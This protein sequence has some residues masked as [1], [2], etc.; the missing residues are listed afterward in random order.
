MGIFVVIAFLALSS[1]S[2]AALFWRLRQQ[3]VSIR[4]WALF[5]VLVACGFSLGIWCA[6]FCEYHLGSRYRVGSFPFPV[7]FFHFEDSHWVDFPV[8]EFQAWATVVAN[9]VTVTAF[10]VLPVWLIS[11]RQHKRE[12]EIRQL[13]KPGRVVNHRPT[14]QSDGSRD[15]SG[16][17][18]FD[19][20]LPDAV[21][22]LD[23]S[24]DKNGFK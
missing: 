6:F 2:L 24:A 5:G 4:I 23:H 17:T 10:A 1:W 16:M 15:L 9:I 22:E 19:S 12:L 21:T 7:V 13:D 14:G 11:W 20:A 8:T 3:H 18:A